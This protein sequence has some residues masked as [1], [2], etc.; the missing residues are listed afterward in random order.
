V[1]V[2]HRRRIVVGCS[3][4]CTAFGPRPNHGEIYVHGH[5]TLSTRRAALDQLVD[6]L[7]D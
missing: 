3:P 4:D 5:V 6:A 2:L 1:L 7:S